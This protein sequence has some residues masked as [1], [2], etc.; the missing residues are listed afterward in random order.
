V[1][2]CGLLATALA[3]PSS[4]LPTET[5]LDGFRSTDQA[6]P[7]E[8]KLQR[9]AGGDLVTFDGSLVER[10][11]AAGDF[12]AVLA[13]VSALHSAPCDA[14]AAPA[15]V[16][17]GVFRVNPAGTHVLVGES[18]YDGGADTNGEMW[19]V[20]L[21]GSGATFAG[22]LVFNKDAAF[23]STGTVVLSAVDAGW[24]GVSE[25][26]RLDTT[27]AA[28]T[29]IATLP[30]ASGPVDVDDADNVYYAT[31]TDV[32]TEPPLGWTEVL[33]FQAA[34]VA[35]GQPERTEADAFVLA[36]GFDG[37]SGLAV[38][39][40]PAEVFL[41]DSLYWTGGNR[42]WHVGNTLANSL[43]LAE[44]PTGS[45]ISDLQYRSPEAGAMYLAYQP[46]EGGAVHYTAADFVNPPAR[47]SLEPARPTL[48]A[49]GAGTTGPGPVTLTLEGG[50]PDAFWFLVWSPSALFTGVESSL[51]YEGV[52][53]FTGLDFGT[54]GVLTT[55]LVTDAAGTGSLGYT[56]PG[57]FEGLLA[58]QAWLVNGGAA[59]VGTSTHAIP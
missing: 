21:D 6:F 9:L 12:L 29:R 45:F 18:S 33:L 53:L 24:G 22:D 43:L 15:C 16:F 32:F 5:V 37:A 52:P 42:L 13:D 56:N 58:M 40:G 23:E 31:V 39:S 11:S 20:A 54:L 55:P 59:F 49:T 41:A 34:Q 47:R 14:F 57:G 38:G 17:P 1:A 28:A 27:T 50:A 44:G 35:P 48:T 2:L 7:R 4:A 26:W 30:G 8:A 3:V 10:W 51:V 36:S 19:M 25:L 46:V